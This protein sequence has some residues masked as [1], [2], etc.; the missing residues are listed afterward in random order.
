MSNSHFEIPAIVLS[1]GPMTYGGIMPSAP[2]R[3]RSFGA[4][5]QRRHSRDVDM[6]VGMFSDDR[7][8]PGRQQGSFC[9]ARRTSR[10]IVRVTADRLRVP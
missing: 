8:D 4:R 7:R 10:G 9:S 6:V 3:A 1:G 5:A 2:A